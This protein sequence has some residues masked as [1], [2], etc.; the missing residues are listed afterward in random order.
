MRVEFIIVKLSTLPNFERTIYLV[1]IHFFLCQHRIRRVNIRIQ[2]DY[3]YMNA[4]CHQMRVF[5]LRENL[6][7]YCSLFS[8]RC[9]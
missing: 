8:G 7:N 5:R 9:E 6:H 3:Y 2:N 4:E 1:A